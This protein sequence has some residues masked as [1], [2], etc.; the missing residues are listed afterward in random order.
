MQGQRAAKQQQVRFI[1]ASARV[2]FER[3][4]DGHWRVADLTVLARPSN[5][6]GAGK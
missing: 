1:T 3:S 4:A 6:T 5:V 2:S